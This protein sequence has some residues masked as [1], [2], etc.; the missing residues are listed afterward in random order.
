MGMACW[1]VGPM[2]LRKG[3]QSF[4]LPPRHPTPPSPTHLP[5]CRS[6]SQLSRPRPNSSQTRP[7]GPT[8][9]MPGPRV[10]PTRPP[11]H[12]PAQVLLV[13]QQDQSQQQV[14]DLVRPGLSTCT[15]ARHQAS[16][17]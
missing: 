14:G 13:A 4:R 15:A 2:N 10:P 1:S 6:F 16:A 5:A 9:P 17:G 8:S 11:T 12:A 3:A 7:Q